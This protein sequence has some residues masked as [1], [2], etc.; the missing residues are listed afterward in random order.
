MSQSSSSSVRPDRRWNL[1]GMLSACQRRH[2]QFI[3]WS[4]EFTASGG[5]EGEQRRERDDPSVTTLS[6]WS[7]VKGRRLFVVARRNFDVEKCSCEETQGGHE[8]VFTYPKLKSSKQKKSN[9]THGP[10][11]QTEKGHIQYT[12]GLIRQPRGKEENHTKL[13]ELVWPNWQLH[14]R[15][16]GVSKSAWPPACTCSHSTRSRQKV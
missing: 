11:D 16:C 2:Q 3:A 7:P 10:V 14:P 6:L 12:L 5:V 1:L 8:N 15:S 9:L 13:Q 4:S